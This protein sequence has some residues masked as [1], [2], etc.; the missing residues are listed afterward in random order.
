MGRLEDLGQTLLTWGNRVFS[1]WLGSSLALVTGLEEYI[2][3][4][5]LDSFPTGHSPLGHSLIPTLIL[6][7]GCV[8]RRVYGGGCGT[9]N[10]E[11]PVFS[12]QYT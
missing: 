7:S 12:I 10:K 11:I 5:S 9:K 1:S 3:T 6:P 8:Q 4:E 2:S